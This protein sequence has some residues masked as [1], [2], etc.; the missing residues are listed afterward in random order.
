MTNSNSLAAY[1]PVLV[2]VCFCVLVLLVGLVF[3]VPQPSHSAFPTSDSTEPIKG[4]AY[5]ASSALLA[6]GFYRVVDRYDRTGEVR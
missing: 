5:I 6:C 3:T 1:L 4:V 2:F